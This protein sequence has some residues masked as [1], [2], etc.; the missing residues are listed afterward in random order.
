MV[1]L[2]PVV[3]IVSV[4]AFVG[5]DV[6]TKGSVGARVFWTGFFVGLTDGDGVGCGKCVHF[7]DEEGIM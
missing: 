5:F 1:S 7:M 4:G 3:G 2:G 6:D